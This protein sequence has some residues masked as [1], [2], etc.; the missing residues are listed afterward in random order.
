MKAFKKILAVAL[1]AVSV[2]AIAA[3]AM[4]AYSTMYVDCPLGETVRLRKTPSTSGVILAN[5][6]RGTAVQAEYYNS[7]WHKVQY[8]G[9]TGYMMSSFLSSSIPTSNT[10]WLDRYGV[11]TLSSGSGSSHYVR[12]LQIDLMSLG[13]NLTPYY[14]DGYYGATTEGAVRSFQRSHPPLEV[15]GICGDQTKEAIFKALFGD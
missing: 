15:D 1:I 12:V 13:Y 4:A 10:P 5:I 8:N 14:D 6:P 11:E 9:N 2:M 3:P 7:T